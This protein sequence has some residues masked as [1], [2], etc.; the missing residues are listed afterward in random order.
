MDVF[1]LAMGL[2]LLAAG[3]FLLRDFSRFLSSGYNAKGKVVSI[4]Q[5]LAGV[6]FSSPPP[7]YQNINRY[8]FY[9]VIEYLSRGE[10]V[11]FTMVGDRA[12]DQYH[13]GDIIDLRFNRSRRHHN[14]VSR[15]T[16]LLI[17][18]LTVLSA[19][20]L[21]GAMF[22]DMGLTLVHICFSS[23]ILTLCLFVMVAYYRC[24]DESCTEQDER[25]RNGRR[26][27]LISEPSAFNHWAAMIDDGGQKRRILGSQL[28]GTG[29]LM[30]GLVVVV[31]A[32]FID[33]AQIAYG[34]SLKEL[35]RQFERQVVHR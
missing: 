28:F 35:N 21:A 1:T 25:G 20:L 30:S 10:S 13:I 15:S 3:W 6:S 18:M 12:P 33:T 31:A 14:R 27:I 24:Q 16:V 2:T 32:F 17:T 22:A 26:R 8:G 23:I 5:A 19:A 11:L 4:Q 29:C 7:H 34:G 9:P